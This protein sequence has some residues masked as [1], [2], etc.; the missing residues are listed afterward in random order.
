MTAASPQCS[1]RRPGR[2][3]ALLAF[4]LIELLT[5]I[6]IVGVLAAIL[7]PVVSKV[8]QTAKNVKC[9]NNLRQ[10]GTAMHLFAHDNKGRLPAVTTSST[11]WVRLLTGN[12]SEGTD[13]VSASGR[14]TTVASGRASV[15]ICEQNVGAATGTP[16]TSIGQTY[17]MNYRL[18]GI[19]LNA[20]A[21][22][23]RTCLVGDVVFAGAGWELVMRPDRATAVP[24]A[25][26]GG[27]YNF[28][29][30]DGHVAVRDDYPTATS[31]PFWLP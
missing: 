15:F 26:H 16:G 18:G 1:L 30:V 11:N 29:H 14:I 4:T 23:A 24:A 10:V 8:R 25:V 31:D 3:P 27:K 9:I 21:Q 20:V 22:P 28:L 5:V 19:A 17:G 12:S 6:A 13:Y 7:I 2:R